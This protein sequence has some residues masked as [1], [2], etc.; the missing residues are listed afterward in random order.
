MTLKKFFPILALGVIFTTFCWFAFSR[1]SFVPVPWPDGSAFYL[2][3]IEFLREPHRW[4]MHSQAAFIPSYD[5]ANFNM[6]PLLPLILG[7]FTKIGLGRFLGFPLAIKVISLSAFMA[8]VGL[9]GFGLKKLSRS[10]GLAS[11]VGLAALWDPVTRWG[12][13]VVRSEIWIGLIWMLL[14]YELIFFQ[15]REIS[16]VQQKRSLWIMAILLALGAYIHFE[17]I[18]LVPATMIGLFRRGN[19]SRQGLGDGQRNDVRN[20]LRNEMKLWITNLIRV[21]ARTLIC[22]APWGVYIFSHFPLFFEQMAV[23]FNRLGR[24][25]LWIRNKFLMFHSLFL[26]LGSPIGVPK[27][28]NVAKGVFWLLIISL[29]AFTLKVLFFD[30]KERV[31]F[32]A[33]K[34]SGDLIPPLLAAGAAFWTSFYL[35]CTKPEVWFITLCHV[36]LWPWL[37]VTLLWLTHSNETSNTKGIRNFFG[38]CAVIYAFV[39][40]GA[41]LVLH[42]RIDP[43][44]SWS[45]YQNW[46]SCIERTVSTAAKNGNLKVWQPH[47]PD[48][49][50]ELSARRPEWDLTRTLDF[51]ALRENAYRYSKKADAIIMTRFFDHPLKKEVD[52]LAYEGPERAEDWNLLKSESDHPFGPWILEQLP[53]LQPGQWKRSVC[54]VGPFL[55]DISVKT[56]NF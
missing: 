54:S 23:Q 55:A 53:T 2:P 5:V 4:K 37:G 31:S 42:R 22:L 27:F 9:L 17:A 21:G 10:W 36:T 19:L 46:V 11:A 25:N 26:E 14:L 32:K 8:G 20:N 35:W 39:S 43:A 52:S 13:S 7:V 18:I 44:Y 38:S 12:T 24:E 34:G 41:T 56:S 33:E 6:M 49:L 40:L 30:Q 3:S 48:V 45:S 16:I 47:L 28:F 51:E 15:K 29:T 1:L 50:V